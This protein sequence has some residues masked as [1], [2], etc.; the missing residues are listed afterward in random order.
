AVTSARGD[1][2]DLARLARATRWRRFL[3]PRGR[4]AAWDLAG[5]LSAAGL[6]VAEAVLYAAEPAGPPPADVARALAGGEVDLVTVWSPRNGA[7]L[8]DWI[9]THA[10]RLSATDLLGISSNAVAPLRDAGFRRVA[11]ASRPDAA[12]ML[13][14]ISE[15]L[16]P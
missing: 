16:Q 4:E 12:A 1:A 6:E 10:P 9:E 15:A 7:I 2:R 13:R 3:H 8:F 5:E 11:V 14:W